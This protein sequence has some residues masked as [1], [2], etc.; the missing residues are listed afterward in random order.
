MAMGLQN[1]MSFELKRKSFQAAIQ[2]GDEAHDILRQ[3]PYPVLELQLDSLMFNAHKSMGQNVK[4][5][6]YLESYLKIKT[7]LDNERVQSLLN[8]SLVKN[9]VLDNALRISK[10]D[11]ELARKNKIVMVLI[12]VVIMSVFIM[13]I[14]FIWILRSRKQRHLLYVK[15]KLLEKQLKES[16]EWLKWKIEQSV[17]QG[18]SLKTEV[19]DAELPYQQVVFNKRWIY[20]ELRQLF[21][22][23]KL[24]MNPELDIQMVLR[25]LGTNKKY[26]Y[27]ALSNNKENFR[28]FVNRYRIEESKQLI[29]E[30]IEIGNSIL[31]SQIYTEVGFNSNVT[32]Y[33]SFKSMTG[34]TP[35]DYV[36]EKSKELLK[37]VKIQ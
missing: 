8:E 20:Q 34:L 23:K 24:Y 1:L 2:Y 30:H 35:R 9:A 29:N 7:K 6:E 4:A 10:Q 17:N 32:F 37:K 5:L 19:M 33:R 25:E 27:L 18:D 13:S 31:L 15:E 16:D 12:W 11:L 22:S 26:L 28:S 21:E 3:H 36:V 14:G